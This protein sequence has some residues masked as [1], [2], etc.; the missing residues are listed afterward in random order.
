MQIHFT[1]DR[2]WPAGF[3]IV[4]SLYNTWNFQERTEH[5][6]LAFCKTSKWLE[7][8]GVA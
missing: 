7:L 3:E 8:Q 2:N 1:V 5:M 6:E 4:I